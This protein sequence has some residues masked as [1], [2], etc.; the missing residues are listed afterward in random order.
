MEFEKKNDGVE[1]NIIA[2]CGMPGCGKGE[3]AEIAKNMG[4]PVFSMGDV[5][6]F[7]FRHT[8]PERDPIETGI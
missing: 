6:R 4:V 7:H 3:F 2:V 1:M 5:V 8:F